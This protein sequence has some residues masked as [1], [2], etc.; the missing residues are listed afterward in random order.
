[1]TSSIN[2]SFCVTGTQELTEILKPNM[3]VAGPDGTSLPSQPL[4]GGDRKVKS[5]RLSLAV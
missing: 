5:S 4:G 2:I 3:S 1:M